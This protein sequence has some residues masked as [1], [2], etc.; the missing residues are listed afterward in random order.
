VLWVGL[1][2]G[3]GAGK[4]AVSRRLVELGAALV[5]A[6]RIAREVVEPGTPGLAAVE[7]AFGPEVLAPDGS[8]ARESLGRVVFADPGARATLNGI[9]HPLVGERTLALAAEAERQG[10]AVL[11]HDVPLLVENGLAPGYALVVVVTA[12]LAE[13]LRRLVALRGMPEADARARMEAQA[14]DEERAEVADVVLRNDRAL[15]DLDRDVAALWSARLLPYAENLAAG[16]PAPRGPQRVV[17]YDDEWPRAAARLVARLRKVCGSAAVAVE[18][19][20]GTAV[21]G[22]AAVDVIDLQVEVADLDAADA[23]RP[24]LASAGFPRG[25]DAPDDPVLAEIDPHPAQWRRRL[26]STAD[27]GRPADVHVR[28][29]GSAGA[30]AVVALR[31][32]LRRDPQARADVEA[33]ERRLAAQGRDDR[34]DSAQGTAV[35]VPLLVRALRGERPVE[36]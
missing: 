22:M 18:H 27:P 34:D 33:A 5:D 21:P 29:A 9:V 6:D 11:V 26:H 32:L 15:A 24:R 28:V 13:R 19:V 30:R 36:P 20:G 8:L 4:S 23:L 16:R 12:P 3:I 2:G 31:E 10:A 17:A 7:A 14:T 35:P 1:T 25:E